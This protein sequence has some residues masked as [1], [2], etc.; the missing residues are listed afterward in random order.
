MMLAALAIY[1]ITLLLTEQ[2]QL[3]E[4]LTLYDSECL[5]SSVVI[6]DAKRPNPTPGTTKPRY[7]AWRVMACR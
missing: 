5:P 1:W 2:S 6:A 3:C 4:R 7:R